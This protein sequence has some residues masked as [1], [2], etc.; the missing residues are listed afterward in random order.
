M[1]NDNNSTDSGDIYGIGSQEESDVDENYA[2][3]GPSTIGKKKRVNEPFNPCTAGKDIKWRCGLIFGSKQELKTD[4]RE[5]S[6][7]TGR[8]LRYRVDGQHKIHVVCAEGCPF[9]ICLDPIKPTP[10]KPNKR[11]RKKNPTEEEQEIAAEMERAEMEV[12]TREAELMEEALMNEMES[13]QPSTPRRSQR[14]SKGTQNT[15]DEETAT[16]AIFMPTPGVRVQAGTGGTPLVDKPGTS[17]KNKAK[18]P[19]K[20]FRAPRKK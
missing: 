9:R 3:V 17:K 6:I 19:V 12:E 15:Q 13:P 10:H 5:F 2:Y 4:V 8:P 16:P 18:G 20:G 1:F 7:A 11:G 14:I